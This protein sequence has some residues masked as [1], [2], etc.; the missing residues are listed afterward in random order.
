[1]GQARVT[2]RMPIVL[3]LGRLRRELA[4]GQC[5]LHSKTLAQ[6]EATNGERKNPGFHQIK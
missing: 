1:M 5:R 3:T 4:H 2:R 6:K